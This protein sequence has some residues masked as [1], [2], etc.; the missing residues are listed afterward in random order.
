MLS[1]ILV[2]NIKCG[3]CANQIT[4]K[5]MSL[6][7]VEHVDIDVEQSMVSVLVK[8]ESIILLVKS[9]LTSLGYPETGTIE[10]IAAAGA[11]AKSFVSC[12]IGK[13]TKE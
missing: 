7:G 5:L 2:E 8:D 10:G 1:S 13:I 12:A 4:K 11:K 6:P 3:G 9:Q